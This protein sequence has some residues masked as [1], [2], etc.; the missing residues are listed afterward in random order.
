MSL[1]SQVIEIGFGASS[2]RMAGNNTEQP[3]GAP[4]PTDL[5]KR[6]EL[7]QGLQRIVDKADKDESFYDELYDGTYVHSE[8]L[9]VQTATHHS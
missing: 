4:P 1:F 7:P 2:E 5:T 8:V 6:K 9:S 3:R